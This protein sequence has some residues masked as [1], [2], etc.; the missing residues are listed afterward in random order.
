ML[1]NVPVN[2]YGHVETVNKPIHTL[3]GQAYI[4]VDNQYLVLI[5]SPVTDNCSTWISG[6]ERLIIEMISWPISTKERCLTGGSNPWP[7]YQT[8]AHRILSERW[9]SMSH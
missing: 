2:N 1:F 4:W 6:R 8:D 3:P 9:D 5:L 7:E